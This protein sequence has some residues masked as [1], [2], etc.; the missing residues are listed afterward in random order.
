MKGGGRM[1]RP[2]EMTMEIPSIGKLEI[3]QIQED[4]LPGFFIKFN[5]VV[6]GRAE[7]NLD[8]NNLELF[9][10]SQETLDKGKA[11]DLGL[12]SQF[13]YAEDD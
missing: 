3:T 5:G 6:I 10:W 11:G 13:I 2:T 8:T 9:V 4:R 1:K 7:M 12:P